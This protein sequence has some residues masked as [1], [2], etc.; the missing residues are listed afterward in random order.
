ML[1]VASNAPASAY[2]WY[3]DNKLPY[4]HLVSTKIDSSTMDPCNKEQRPGLPRYFYEGDV[5]PA[6]LSLPPSPPRS[7]STGSVATTYDSAVSS[8]TTPGTAAAVPGMSAAGP[9]F[10]TVNNNAL[11][12][13]FTNYAYHLDIVQ[14]PIHARATGWGTKCDSRRPVDPPPVI[15]FEVHDERGNVIT[16]ELSNTF[17]MHVSL[18]EVVELDDTPKRILASRRVSGTTM[19]SISHIRTPVPGKFYFLC[20]DISI[21]QEGRY[22]LEFNVWEV[23]TESRKLVHRGSAMSNTIMVYSAKSFPGLETSSALIKEMASKGCKVRV[24][25][26]SS[27]RKKK[28]KGLAGPGPAASPISLQPNNEYVLNKMREQTQTAEQFPRNNNYYRT[29]SQYDDAAAVAAMQWPFSHSQRPYGKS[30]QEIYQEQQQ[31]RGTQYTVPYYTS[32]RHAPN[33][34]QSIAR[35][36][37]STYNGYAGNSQP[38]AR[39]MGS[40]ASGS[41]A[42]SSSYSQTDTPE[43]TTRDKTYTS[44]SSRSREV[45]RSQYQDTCR[46]TPP[47]TPEPLW[48][49]QNRR[50]AEQNVAEAEIDKFPVQ[51][52]PQSTR[53]SGYYR[54]EPELVQGSEIGADVPYE[55]ASRGVNYASGYAGTGLI[56]Y[57]G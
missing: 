6:P 31:I 2:Q 35:P 8:G 27:L 37:S 5:Y 17:L 41:P 43:L 1:T 9:T 19:V 50:A 57:D 15:Y 24:R 18:Y 42:S 10:E 14:Q 29:T 47:A 25:K 32:T 30:V 53:T 36:S 48:A 11:T 13:G 55:L 49:S 22:Q 28:T 33:F 56:G 34:T 12:D 40:F 20:H 7:G 21:R 45:G 46:F 54:A 4:Q 51:Y 52:G 16:H 44:P 23:A 39:V 26:E 3:H 38:R